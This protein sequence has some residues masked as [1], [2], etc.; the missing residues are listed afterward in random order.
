[1]WCTNCHFFSRLC[2]VFSGVAF[3]SVRVL[4]FCE[5]LIIEIIG[6]VSGL[7]FLSAKAQY[8]AS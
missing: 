2:L 6:V 1:M 7:E 3:V 8:S 5:A 4:V